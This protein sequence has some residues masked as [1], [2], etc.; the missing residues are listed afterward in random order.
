M[1]VSVSETTAEMRIVMPRVMANSRKS[2][3]TTSPMNRSGMRTAMSEMVRERMVKPICFDPLRAACSGLSPCF[4][5]PRDVL[6]HDDGVIDDKARRDGE[7][8]QGEVVEAEPQEIHG[9]EG[10]DEREGHGHARDDRGG[11]VPQEQEDDEHDEG[12]GE[13]QLELHVPDR[14]ADR[15]G[16]VGQYGDLHARPAGSL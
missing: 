9:A 14:C 5:V 15:R 6:D 3:P 10:A 11:Q 7:G 16:A 12:H 8:H 2:L 4:Y 13:H 1:G